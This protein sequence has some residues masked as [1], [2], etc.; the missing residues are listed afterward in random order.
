MKQL[1]FLSSLFT[2]VLFCLTACDKDQK[3]INR[4]DG[5]WEVTSLEI[6]DRSGTKTDELATAQQ[7]GASVEAEFIFEKYKKN[8]TEEGDAFLILATSG[9]FG[10]INLTNTDT[11]T[12]YYTI[13]DDCES[14][15]L[16]DKNTGNKSNGKILEFSNK[17]VILEAYDAENDQTIYVKMQKK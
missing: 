12:F 16:E 10:G 17:E 11:T 6:T 4:L 2:L 14:I 15:E 8:K 9:S 1:L 13:L 3:C 7:I 5:D